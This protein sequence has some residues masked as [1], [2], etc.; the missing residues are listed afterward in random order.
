MTT[1]SLPSVSV[2]LLT[3]NQE[4]FVAEALRSWLAQDLPGC[5]LVLADD[6]STDRTREI[7]DAELAAHPAAQVRVIHCHRPSNGGV[8]ANINAAMAACTGDIIVAAAGDDVSEPSRL[9][10]AAEIFAADPTV[11]AVV[12]NCQKIDADGRSLGHP[13][14]RHKSGRYAYDL[15]SRD[16]YARSPVC[17]AS[18]AYRASLFR[19]FGPMQPGFHGED[20]CFWVRALLRG[21][22][23]YDRRPLVR[24]RQHGANLSNYSEGGFASPESRQRHL[25][26]MRAHELM[27]PQ[28]ERDVALA[29]EQGWV[30][31]ERGALVVDLA[32][33]ECAR[34]KLDRCSLEPV[35]WS[36]W[37]EAAMPFLRLGRWSLVYRSFRKWLNR[38]RRER[39]WRWWAKV[40]QQS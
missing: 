25:R 3:Y 24:W 26:W 10:A 11:Q 28:W 22:V 31:P 35:R 32:R 40:R 21:A 18:A 37:K 8:L 1:P 17:G 5:E 9:R 15:D 7:I 13:S 29:V 2:I 27:A 14:L 36:E 19:D 20:N 34:W 6:A 16:I 30:S 33:L 23:Y 4:A 38:Y 12:T 39:E